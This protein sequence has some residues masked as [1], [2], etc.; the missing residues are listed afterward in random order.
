MLVLR[1][2]V[3]QSVVMGEAGRYIEL[4]VLDVRADEVSIDVHFLRPLQEYSPTIVAATLK[5]GEQFDLQPGIQVH[6]LKIADG[7]ATIGFIAPANCELH[8]REIWDA[9]ARENRG[10]FGDPEDGLAGAPV[11]RK[12]KP[13]GDSG[14]ASLD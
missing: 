13:G 7:R 2:Q 10:T 6:V 11:P 3:N 8:R 4:T 12:P 9:V 1:R 5:K 14:A